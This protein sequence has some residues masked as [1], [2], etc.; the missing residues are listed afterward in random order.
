MAVTKKPVIKKNT[1]GMRWSISWK[2]WLI[3]ASVTLNIAFVV[4][5]ITMMTSHALDGMFMKEGLSRYCAVANDYQ[6]D[7]APAK[8]K[9]LRVFTCAGG[10]AKPYFDEGFQKYLDF[11]GVKS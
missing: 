5:L 4:V 7:T 2:N 6:F 10:D 8:V 1:G 9:A 3:A 11:K